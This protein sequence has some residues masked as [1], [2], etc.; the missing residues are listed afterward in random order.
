MDFQFYSGNL[1]VFINQSSV[2]SRMV[3][4]KKKNQTD[5]I[6][7]LVKEL[8]AFKKTFRMNNVKRFSTKEKQH[9]T[10]LIQTNHHALTDGKSLQ[11]YC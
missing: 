1:I 11:I 3:T 7:Q 4:K 9:G 10:R 5:Q 2:D 6:V 8:N